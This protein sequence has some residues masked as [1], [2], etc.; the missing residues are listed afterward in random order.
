MWGYVENTIIL[1]VDSREAVMRKSDIVS[2]R[3]GSFQEE[4]L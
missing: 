2:L 1:T 4:V 3:E